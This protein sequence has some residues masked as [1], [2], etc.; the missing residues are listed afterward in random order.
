MSSCIDYNLKSMV[1]IEFAVLA[2]ENVLKV[3]WKFC[4]G[5]E[6]GR[7]GVPGGGCGIGCWY[8]ACCGLC[9]GPATP[10]DG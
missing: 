1:F 6:Y 9:G 7:I 3:T 10:P 2:I 5:P 8:R 4:A